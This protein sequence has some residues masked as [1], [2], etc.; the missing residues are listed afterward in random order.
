[1]QSQERIGSAEGSLPRARFELR[2]PLHMPSVTGSALGEQ[3]IA[4]MSIRESYSPANNGLTSL[5]S[6]CSGKPVYSQTP[7]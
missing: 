5:Q 3:Q 2:P 6:I 4:N 1:M 7:I